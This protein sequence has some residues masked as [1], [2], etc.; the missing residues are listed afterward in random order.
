MMKCNFSFGW[1]IPFISIQ[2]FMMC[3]LFWMVPAWY[4]TNTMGGKVI[5]EAAEREDNHFCNSKLFGLFD[6]SNCQLFN[7]VLAGSVSHGQA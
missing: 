6:L 4:T 7:L 1:V 2:K 3:V 5:E